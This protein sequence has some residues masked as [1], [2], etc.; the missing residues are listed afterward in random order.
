MEVD[1]F[2]IYVSTSFGIAGTGDGE[3][4]G[5]GELLQHADQAMDAAK[6]AD[7]NQIFLWMIDEAVPEHLVFSG[8]ASKRI[9]KL[10]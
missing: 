7:R 2:E 9:E 10:S 1:E 4:V 8:L 6:D 5:V 3:N